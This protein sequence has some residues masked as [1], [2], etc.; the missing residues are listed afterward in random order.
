VPVSRQARADSKSKRDV[1]G[2]RRIRSLPELPP[3]PRDAHKGNFG[4]VLVIGGS[5]GMIG[6]PALVAN[7]ALRS[8]A[9]L[10]TVACPESIQPV[11]ASLCPCATSIPLPE[12]KAGLID[13]S[14]ALKHLRKL[15]LIG[16]SG[17]PTALAAGPGLGQ[18][19]P[20]FSKS[21][22]AL[23]GAFREEAGIPCVLDADA[24]NAIAAVKA[25]RAGKRTGRPA[26]SA[27]PGLRSTIVT[28]HPGEMARLHG[29]STAEVQENREG[30]AIK[31]VEEMAAGEEDRGRSIVVLKGAQ[32]VVTDGVRLF[33]NRTGNPGMATGGSGDVLTGVIVGLIAQGLSVFD[34]AVLGVHVH[35][36]AGDLAADDVGE[37]SLI[38]ADLVGYLPEA[39]LTQTHS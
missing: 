14:R 22:L 25:V 12:T 36:L 37:I 13:P 28:P 33:I 34:A 27:L 16:E 7:S 10:V 29:V 31:T 15:G 19:D 35:G 2:V 11:V 1:Q 9:G 18:G 26:H 5:R 21:V 30:F 3:R 6:A 8:G 32:T 38:A 17:A 24:L 20:A 23:I 4:R 39:F